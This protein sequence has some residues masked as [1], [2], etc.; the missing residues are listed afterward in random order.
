MNRTE[1]LLNQARTYLTLAMALKRDCKAYKH[2]LRASKRLLQQAEELELKEKTA[3][4]NLKL[5]A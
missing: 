2:Y 5:V 3:T 1:I 4:Y